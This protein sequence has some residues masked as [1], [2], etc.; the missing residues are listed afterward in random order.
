LVGAVLLI[1][2][3]L[4]LDPSPFPDSFDGLGVTEVVLL[5]CVVEV[6]GVPVVTAPPDEVCATACGGAAATRRNAAATAVAASVAA[7]GDLDVTV[8]ALS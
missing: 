7:A 5:P 1:V 8:G 4:V 2:L 6:P 3:W